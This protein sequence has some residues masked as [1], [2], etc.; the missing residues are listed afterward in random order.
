MGSFKEI[1]SMVG[2]IILMIAVFAGAYYVSKFVGKRYQP[3]NGVT[4]NI[5]VL[6]SQNVGK[7][8]ALLIVKAANRVFLIGTASHEFTLI[9][10]LN[11]EDLI[12]V[13]EGN[14]MKKDF[15]AVLRSA[16]LGKEKKQ[17]EGEDR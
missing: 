11:P 8:K 2:T 9:S 3:R 7:D 17:N 12:E 14:S 16:L 5:S 1:A 6:E 13:P 4:R 10:E 15:S